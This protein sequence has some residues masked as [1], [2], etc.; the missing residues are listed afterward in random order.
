M[1]DYRKTYWK[2]YRRARKK[3]YSPEGARRWAK[4]QTTKDKTAEIVSSV[5]TT[6]PF[7]VTACCL[8]GVKKKIDDLF[9]E[10]VMRDRK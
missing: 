6:I 2:Y 7:F 3:G 9:G 5:M 8:M 4:K 10:K 1:K